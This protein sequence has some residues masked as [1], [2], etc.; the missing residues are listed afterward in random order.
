MRRFRDLVFWKKLVLFGAT[1]LLVISILIGVLSYRHTQDAARETGR[2]S[3]SDA[4]NRIDISIT[5]RSRQINSAMQVMYNILTPWEGEDGGAAA[6][7]GQ[8]EQL[9]SQLT[10]PFPEIRSISIL[11]GDR[12][13]YTAGAAVSPS[14]SALE[15]MYQLARW[16]PGRV[17]WSEPTPGDVF[18]SQGSASPV[19]PVL[20]GI[21]DARGSTV[22]LILLGVD[23]NAAGSAILAKQRILNHQTSLLYSRGSRRIYSDNMVPEDLQALM[24]EQY[25]AG[26]RMFTV[27][28]DGKD[29]CCYAQYNGMVGWV[30]FSLIAEEYL[31]PNAASLRRYI[32]LLVVICV[33]LASVF[34]MVLARVITGPL[35]RLNAAMRQAQRDNFD[36]HLENDRRD[37]IGELTDSFNYMMDQIRTLINRVYQEKLA[38]MNAEMEMLQAQINPHFL[39]NTLDTIN[40]MLIDQDE[41]EISAIVVALGKLMQYSMDTSMSLVPL[42]EEYRNARDFLFLQKTRLEDRLEYQLELEEGLEEFRIPKLILQPLIENSLKHGAVHAAQRITVRVLTVRRG[43]RICITVADDGA[44]MDGERL[45]ACRRLLGSA[46]EGQGRIGLPNVARRLQLHFEGR[47]EFQLDSQPGQGTTLRL[48]LPVIGEGEGL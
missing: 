7:L 35:A 1:P 3:L 24:L 20:Q 5:V 14:D 48:W 4:V 29:Y 42:R 17:V 45:A 27:T 30:T 43:E 9:C 6:D 11:L 28:Y 32:V 23:P 40:W 46:G 33:T 18:D 21:Q 41:M 39:Y 37:E 36:I 19:I 2:K 8:M 26:R 47:C 13:A 44:G 38:Q 15:E 25:R 16:F 31:F 34:L 10:E 22:G 12:V